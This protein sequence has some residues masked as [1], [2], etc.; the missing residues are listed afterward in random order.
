M[1]RKIKKHLEKEGVLNKSRTNS[2]LH[3]IG[4]DAVKSVSSGQKYSL[5]AVEIKGK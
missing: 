1:I 5:I 2:F 3:R 4:L